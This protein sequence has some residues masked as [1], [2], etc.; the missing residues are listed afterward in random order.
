MGS[1][2]L[3]W[4][5]LHGS[6]WPGAKHAGCMGTALSLEREALSWLGTALP[7]QREALS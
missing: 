7:L 5:L 1:G 2:M 6:S 3:L 4:C